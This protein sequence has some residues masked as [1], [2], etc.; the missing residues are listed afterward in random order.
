MI[1]SVY[2]IQ[3]DDLRCYYACDS[4][5]DVPNNMFSTWENLRN[6]H[7]DRFE[8]G[9]LSMR[10]YK[11]VFECNMIGLSTLGIY[12]P[13]KGFFG[14]IELS[15]L[16][17]YAP[18]EGIVGIIEKIFKVTN[19]YKRL[20]VPAILNGILKGVQNVL[21]GRE[22]C[23]KRGTPIY[24][25]YLG[26]GYQINALLRTMTTGDVISIQNGEETHYFYVDRKGFKK[27]RVYFPR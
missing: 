18:Q 22:A 23:L 12:S 10:P 21:D 17:I 16:K 11:K 4:F 3:P 9:C 7:E 26:P 6:H 25:I 24:G 13:P 20:R 14:R 19:I 2:Q 15:M 5:R 1:V 27:I 8:N